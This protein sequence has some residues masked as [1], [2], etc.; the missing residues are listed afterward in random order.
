MS[1]YEHNFKGS[2]VS[3]VEGELVV[4]FPKVAYLRLET[5]SVSVNNSQNTL[6]FKARVILYKF[7]ING[8]LF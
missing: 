1:I 7:I 2:E 3:C 6:G 4:A 5:Q 8:M